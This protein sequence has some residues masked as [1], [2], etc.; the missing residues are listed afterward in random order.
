VFIEFSYR[1][2]VFTRYEICRLDSGDILGA[3]VCVLFMQCVIR[4]YTFG[5]NIRNVNVKFTMS[6]LANFIKEPISVTTFESTEEER[7]NPTFLI[8]HADR[9]PRNNVVLGLKGQRS[10]SRS[11]S[12]GE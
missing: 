3:A 1:S 8:T 6:C 11:R 12:Q 4:L 2:R 9:Y 5:G 10:R 7:T